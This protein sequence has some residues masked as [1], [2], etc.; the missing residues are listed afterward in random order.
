[1]PED[2][3][4]L[5]FDLRSHG[6]PDLK[7]EWTDDKRRKSEQCV[8]CGVLAEG[9]SRL[10]IGDKSESCRMCLRCHMEKVLLPIISDQ[11]GSLLPTP[12]TETEKPE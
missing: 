11:F 9:S 2:R 3:S 5:L 10:S 12:T 6:T 1:M 4:S 7:A 8:H